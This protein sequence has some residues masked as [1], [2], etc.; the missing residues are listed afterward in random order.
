MP[1][2]I[3]VDAGFFLKRFPKTY[4]DKDKN[5]PAVVSK[6]LHEMSLDHLTQ[7]GDGERKDLYR[8]FVY[9]CPPYAKK[10]TYAKSKQ[11]I[12]FGETPDVIFRLQLQQELMRL[13][14]VVLRLGRIDC[15]SWQLKGYVLRELVEGARAFDELT[16]DDFELDVR[17]KGVDMKI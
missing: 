14:K 12:D 2:A 17:Q 8:I 6:T 3:F 10:A 1:T 7:S 5:D 11:P 9:D 15:N 4:R 16:D 13:R